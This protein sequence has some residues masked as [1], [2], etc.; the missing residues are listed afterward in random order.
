[1]PAASTPDAD[2][3]D[4]ILRRRRSARAFG[5]S[6]L[7]P[8]EVR[9]LLWAAQGVTGPEGRRTTPSPRATFLLEVIAVT[10]EAVL[11]YDAPSD[12]LNELVTGDVRA[13]LWSASGEQDQVLAAPLTIVL[14]GSVERL[15]SR[16]DPSRALR[17]L[18]LEAGHAGQNV[19]LE[20]T[21]LGL[22]GVPMGSFDDEAVRRVV[23]LAPD[24]APFEMISVGHPR[25]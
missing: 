13:A 3:L 9:H 14:A 22:V 21:A 24:F 5:P 16:V 25:D 8:E 15:S 12:G 18:V 11:E 4:A 10:P 2:A 7:T 23:R 1:M 20:A 19:L 6:P 17:Y